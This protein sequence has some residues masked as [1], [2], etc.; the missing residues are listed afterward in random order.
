MI[1]FTLTAT[2]IL[3]VFFAFAAKYKLYDVTLDLNNRNHKALIILFGGLCVLASTAI[4]IL[5][6]KK[7]LVYPYTFD[8]KYYNAYEQLFD[9]F[10]KHQLN[11]DVAVDEKF[12]IMNNPYDWSERKLLD[13]SCL[14][15]RVLFDGKYYSYFGIAPIIL[16]YFPFW[17]I[18][19][20]VP[21]AETVCFILSLIAITA[22]AFLFVKLI[23]IFTKKPNLFLTLFGVLAVEL[24]SLVLMVQS[25][26]DMY[27]IAVE[28]GIAFLSLFLLFTF[29]AYETKRCG[30]RCLY[31]ALSGIALS[32]LVMSRPN[33]AIFF[34][35]AIPVYFSTLLSKDYKISAK[36][37][38]VIA[39]ALPVIIGAAFV[40]WYNYMRFGSVLEFG[41]KYQ[42]T[43]YDVSK[44]GFSA[45]LILPSVYYY[46]IQFPL[47]EKTFPCLVLPFS[48]P[49]SY[50]GY[51]YATSTIGMFAFPST[52]GALMLP[53]TLH[54][55]DKFKKS[56]F[57]LAFLACVVLAYFDMCF[58]GICIRYLCDIALVMILFSAVCLIDFY[59]VFINSKNTHK[60]TAFIIISVVLISSVILGTMLVF[61]N[62]RDNLIKL[63]AN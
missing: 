39:F 51:L 25:S 53:A 24:G 3:L 6:S 38:Q 2:V 27:Y 36:I 40:M 49:I 19:K 43:V 15:D 63:F 9:A 34:V 41:A 29:C 20:K 57:T 8:V 55:T 54:K 62:E 14:W 52:W 11:I 18:T 23:K 33:M 26:A 16:I 1:T 56:V 42:L 50:T 4:F 35:V 17:F 13:V 30:K 10:M 5:L 12:S 22:I 44:Y 28:S 61:N 7:S 32:F 21:T 48:K 59:E 60:I 47:F 46:F 31:F 45:A 58:G 37:S